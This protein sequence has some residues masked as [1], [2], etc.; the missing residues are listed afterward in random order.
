[1]AATS[2]DSL[3]FEIEVP[4]QVRTGEPV[5]ITLRATNS[6]EEPLELY[7]RGRTIAFDITVA[8][9]DGS[10]VWRRLEGQMI[11]AILQ[12]RELAPGESLEFHDEWDQRANS[13]EPVSSGHY[14]VQGALL[15]DSPRPLETPT[16][17]L[18]ILPRE[19]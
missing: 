1:M 4:A 18:L 10:V 7:L 13:G 3:R 16:A 8:G 11:P 6:G 9:E 12:V 17:P 5:P 15:R 14:T 19:R 2:A